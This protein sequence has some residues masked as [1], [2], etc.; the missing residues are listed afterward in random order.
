[1]KIQFSTLAALLTSTLV[2]PVALADGPDI[3][4]AQKCNS[5]HSVMVAGI[6]RTVPPD[7]DKAPDLS[8]VGASLDKKAI[9]SFLLKKSEINGEKHKKSFGGTTDEL[10]TIATWLESLK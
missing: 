5:C 8:K 7:D 3:F 2:A 6:S 4:K 1:M 10:K 9:A